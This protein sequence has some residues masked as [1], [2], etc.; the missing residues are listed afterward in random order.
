MAVTGCQLKLLAVG[1]TQTNEVGHLGLQRPGVAAPPP[2]NTSSS[3]LSLI[4]KHGR[5][6]A[7]TLGPFASVLKVIADPADADGGVTDAECGS[8]TD[9][10]AGI[11]GDRVSLRARPRTVTCHG[12]SPIVP[13]AIWL[14]L[15]VRPPGASVVPG[16]RI[17][18]DR[19][20]GWRAAVVL[21]RVTERPATDRGAASEASA[22][23]P[24]ATA[25][26]AGA[27]GQ[28]RDAAAGADPARPSRA[29]PLDR[30]LAERHRAQR[31]VTGLPRSSFTAGLLS[32]N[33]LVERTPVRSYASVASAR[34]DAWLLTVPTEQLSAA[35]VSAS[36]RSSQ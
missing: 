3:C 4:G 7:N 32:N 19:V 17:V 6:L 5:G 26:T 14:V 12:V 16:G 27:C 9:R 21:P 36:D 33:V 29:G 13:W 20:V 1:E 23:Y 15:L 28:Q 22:G 2:S 11:G 35:A 18:G 24:A 31:T 8:E 30:C 34:A 10:E 25:T